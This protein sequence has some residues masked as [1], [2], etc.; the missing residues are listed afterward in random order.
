MR[1]A[2]FFLDS[3]KQACGTGLFG[4]AFDEAVAERGD[5]VTVWSRSIDK[6]SA[7]ERFGISVAAAPAE[8]VRDAARVHLVLKDDAVVDHVIAGARAGLVPDAVLIDHSTT[9]PALT[10]GR[11]AGLAAAGVKFLHHPVFMLPLAARLAKGSMLV[12]GPRPVFDAVSA[13]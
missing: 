13:R 1:N 2:A 6:E 5:R 12:S 7:L 9:L 3:R 11:M 10:V 8:A 4:D